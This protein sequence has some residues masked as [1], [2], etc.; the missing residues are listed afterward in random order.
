MSSPAWL[1]EYRSGKWTGV[2]DD[3]HTVVWRITSTKPLKANKRHRSPYSRA[4][5]ATWQRIIHQQSLMYTYYPI[6]AVPSSFCLMGCFHRHF[7]KINYIQHWTS[8]A[9]APQFNT[10]WSKIDE[11]G[12]LRNGQE[13]I[14]LGLTT[15][16]LCSWDLSAAEQSVHVSWRGECKCDRSCSTG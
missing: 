7:A 8:H 10:H 9:L 3:L 4:L 5:Q 1:E 14:L 13:P 15:E 6:H 11:H 12:V 16:T 2:D